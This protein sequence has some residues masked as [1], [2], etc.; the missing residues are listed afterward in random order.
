MAIFCKAASVGQVWLTAVM[1]LVAGIPQVEC[2][3]ARESARPSPAGKAL[4]A[5]PCCCG[6][7]CCAFQKGGCCRA[8]GSVPSTPVL[9]SESG[10]VSTSSHGSLQRPQCRTALAQ[11]DAFS[12]AVVKTS[13]PLSAVPGPVL[14]TPLVLMPGIFASHS[15]APLAPP[16]DLVT[17][18][19]HFLI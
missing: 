8:R 16:P 5:S 9:A 6:G 4:A 18:H 12:P 2:V 3:C 13:V 7:G 1:T 19:Q 17:L 10:N 11:P 14:Y 15:P